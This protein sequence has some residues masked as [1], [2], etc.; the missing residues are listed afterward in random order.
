MPM[1]YGEPRS[2][3]TI[4]VVPTREGGRDIREGAGAVKRNRSERGGGQP[5]DRRRRRACASVAFAAHETRAAVLPVLLRA[6]FRCS[7]GD[8]QAR[9]TAGGPKGSSG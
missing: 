1:I 6:P 7:F 8:R 4:S 9:Q 5:A 2:S 3:F